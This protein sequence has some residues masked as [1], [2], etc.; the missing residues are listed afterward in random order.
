M[1][2]PHAPRATV[3]IIRFRWGREKREAHT[4]AGR[5]TARERSRERERERER[6]G[7]DRKET[8]TW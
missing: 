3:K 2:S 5:K 7:G 4:Q 1:W 6:E 8:E